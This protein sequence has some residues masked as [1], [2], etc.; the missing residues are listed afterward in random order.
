MGSIKLKS[1]SDIKSIIEGGKHLSEIKGK[2]YEKVKVGVS[3]WEIEELAV[4]LIKKS[5]GE[6]AFKRVPKYSWATCVNINEGI[7]HGIPEKGMVFQEKDIVSVDVGLY[8]RGFNTDTSFSKG[9]GVS[10][11]HKLFLDTGSKA[12]ENAI[13]KTVTGNYIYDISES[14]ETILKKE[15]YNPVK[16]LVGHGVGKDLHEEPQIPQFVFRKRTETPMIVP[17]M[18]LAI[19]IIYT[20]GSGE[21]SYANDG[22]TIVASDG[23]ISALY[24]DTV[25]VTEN[26]SLR[27]TK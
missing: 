15:G 5:G 3:S 26:S 23:K 27:I 13:A 22:W 4:K 17:G 25:A 21:M 18:V 24:E 10:A 9:L 16:S 8:F 2:L 14:I 11:E 7:V 12:L 20:T 1:G 19:E 6:A